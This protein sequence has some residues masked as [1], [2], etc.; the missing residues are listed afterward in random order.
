MIKFVAETF[1]FHSLFLPCPSLLGFRDVACDTDLWPRQE[2]GP[3]LRCGSG[4]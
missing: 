2:R 4:N 3:G 1:S